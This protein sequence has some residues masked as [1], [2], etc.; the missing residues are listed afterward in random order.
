MAHTISLAWR[1]GAFTQR[2]ASA[3]LGL[4]Q[5]QVS[6]LVRGQFLHPWGHAEVLYHFAV[7]KLEERQ[8]SPDEFDTL[9]NQ[10]IEQLMQAWDHTVDGAHAL[11]D[12][13][14][15]VKRLRV[16]RAASAK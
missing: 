15:G 2:E 11:G 13:L 14:E 9:R 16:S 7:K 12:I 5:G 6:R 8:V 4:D 3:A 10:L 1:V